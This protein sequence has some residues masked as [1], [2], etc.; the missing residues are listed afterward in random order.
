MKR[1]L[2]LAGSW[3]LKRRPR[4]GDLAIIGG[5]VAFE[6]GLYRISPAIAWIAAGVVLVYVGVLL[7]RSEGGTS[8]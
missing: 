4:F 6:Y 2:K 3:I 5:L 1:R 8:T 7:T